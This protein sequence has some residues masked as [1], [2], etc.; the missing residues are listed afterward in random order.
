MIECKAVIF[1]FGPQGEKTGWICVSISKKIAEKINPGVKKSFRIKGFID[2][3]KITSKALLPMGDGDFVLPLKADIRKAIRKT[4][5]DTV[6]L[7]IT[8]DESPV[9][10]N[11]DLVACLAEEPE[12]EAFFNSLALGHR[13]Y[14]SNWIDSARTEQTK[15][16]RIANT[17]N[18]MLKKMDYGQMIRSLKKNR[19]DL[20]G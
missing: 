12:A 10:F 2:D 9:T 20:I 18:A 6:V 4:K 3:Y 16:K 17:V 19:T 8:V 11:E 5:G 1:K 15:T 7:K 14:F 13:K